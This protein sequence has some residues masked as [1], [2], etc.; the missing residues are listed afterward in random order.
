[1]SSDQVSDKYPTR[2]HLFRQS[3]RAT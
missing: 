2:V 1:M 3:I